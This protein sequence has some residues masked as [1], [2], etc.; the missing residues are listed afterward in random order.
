MDHLQFSWR[1]IQ[2]FRPNGAG[3][4]KPRVT[5]WV[6]GRSH[7]ASPERAEH[8]RMLRPF[9]ACNE[10]GRCPPRALFRGTRNLVCV[11]LSALNDDQLNWR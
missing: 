6:F 4:T 5:P 10:G 11:A 1:L 3:H 8:K 2:F 9:R 7:Q